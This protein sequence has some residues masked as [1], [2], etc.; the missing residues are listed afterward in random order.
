[1]LIFYFSDDGSGSSR[2]SQSSGEM[3]STNREEDVNHEYQTMDRIT[4]EAASSAST[5]RPPAQSSSSVNSGRQLPQV[6]SIPSVPGYAKPFARPFDA[7]PSPPPSPPRSSQS[8]PLETNFD[9][10]L[11]TTS[12][13]SQDTLNRNRS[14][15]VGHI[16]ETNFDDP[17]PK[18]GELNNAHSRSMD[19]HQI[20][21]MSLAPQPLETGL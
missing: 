10:P 18:P 21:K 19:G 9:D 20:A 17:E 4:Y 8:R 16:L 12:S 11:P 15:S 1:M 6:P 7:P 5:F 3:G 14:R 2:G 13:N